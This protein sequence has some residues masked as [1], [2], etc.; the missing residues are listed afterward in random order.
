MKG[1]ICRTEKNHMQNGT[2]HEQKGSFEELQG[3]ALAGQRVL[4]GEWPE[5]V[6]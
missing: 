2:R 5:W 6:W 3:F 1:G 4:A